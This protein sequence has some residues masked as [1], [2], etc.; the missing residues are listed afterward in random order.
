MSTEGKAI[1]WLRRDLRLHDNAGLFHAMQSG[2]K[3]QCLFLFDYNISKNLPSTDKRFAFIYQALEK[4]HEQ[5]KS[6]GSS[7]LVKNGFPINVWKEML[8][9]GDVKSIFCNE[10]YEPNA[11]KRDTQVANLA[12]D[13]G[14]SFNAYQDH[15]ICKKGDVL[16]AD[17]TPYTVFTP[18]FNKWLTKVIIDELP[19]Y[20]NVTSDKLVKS[21]YEFPERQVLGFNGYSNFPT[22]FSDFELLK[23]YAIKRDVPGV[24]G[25]SKI[26]A[27]LRF[28]T[29]SIRQA[30][31]LAHK[32]SDVWL[33]EL[34]WREFFSQIMQHFPNTVKEPFKIK[35]RQLQWPLN[36][37]ALQR[38]ID[39][40]TGYPIVDAGMRELR[41]TGWM[42]NRVRMIVAS[43]LCKHLLQDYRLGEAYFAE[44]LIDFEL[45][46]NNGNWQWA[47]GCGCDAAPYFRVF[48]P[49]TQQQK[50]DPKFEYIKQ[51]VPEFG[52]FDYPEPMVDHKQAREKAINFYKNQLETHV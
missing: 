47:A 15:V 8:Q 13:Y 27:A 23:N 36:E 40:K 31:K 2:L 52:T 43:F 3:V 46:S 28:G 16:K 1:F 44:K 20:P 22:D 30:T 7:L 38:W 35:Y 37:D 34:V 5:L 45:S 41:T 42:H 49:T 21:N 12:K 50:F 14:V 48:N 4:I 11:I 32:Y 10:D 39:G 18:Y 19:N 29:I 24:E 9:K 33:K 6:M 26:G 25:T 51:W 17:G